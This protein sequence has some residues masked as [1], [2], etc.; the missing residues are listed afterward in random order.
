[1]RTPPENEISRE[2]VNGKIKYTLCLTAYT[3]LHVLQQMDPTILLVCFM[4]CIT[5]TASAVV[6]MSQVFTKDAA[7]ASVINAVGMLLCVFTM[8]MMIS[9]YELF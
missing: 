8:P 5:P 9:L 6:Q 4:C 7:Y 1:M 3:R 2:V